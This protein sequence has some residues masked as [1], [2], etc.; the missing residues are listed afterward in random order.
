MN[1]YITALFL[2]VVIQTGLADRPPVFTHYMNNEELLEDTKPGVMVYTL[3]GYDPEKLRVTFGVF[4]EV[5]SVEPN[6]GEV[7]LKRRL[8]FERNQVLIVVF[9]ISDGRNVV[10]KTATIYLRD[11]NDVKPAFTKSTYFREIKESFPVGGTVIKDISVTDNEGVNSLLTVTC[12]PGVVYAEDCN[13]F[14]VE[15]TGRES[16]NSWKG[17]L[18]LNKPLNYETKKNY[19]V[20]LVAFDGVN[21][22]TKSVEIRIIDVADIPPYFVRAVSVA[23]AEETPVGTIIT[24][25]SAIDGDK[26]SPRDL[27]YSIYNS[28]NSLFRINED[29]G[30]ISIANRLNREDWILGYSDIYLKVQEVISKS[31]LVLG[32]SNTTTATTTIRVNILDINDNKPFFTASYVATIPEDIVNNE[33]IPNLLM[34]VMDNDTGTNANYI[35]QMSTYFDTFYIQPQYGEGISTT[36]IRVKNTSLIDYEKGPREYKFEVIAREANTTEKYSGSTTVTI[37]V[38]DVNDNVPI[39]SQPFYEVSVNELAKAG[40]PVATITATDMDSGK[41]GT[42]GIRYVRLKGMFSN[43]FDLNQITGQV[44]VASCTTPGKYPCLDYD[45]RKQINLTVE[46]VDNENIGIDVQR[47]LTNVIINVNDAN[48]NIPVF[49]NANYYGKIGEGNT[50]PAPEV[51]VKAEDVDVV[52]SPVRY[53][54]INSEVP[55]LFQIGLFSGKI[56]AVR[57]VKITDSGSDVYITMEVIASDGVASAKASVRIE[58]LDKNDNKPV[59]QQNNYKTC[60]P[61]NFAGGL[62]VISVVATDA[63]KAG[64]SNS[65]LSYSLATGAEGQFT[66]DQMGMIKSS[67]QARFDYETKKIYAFQVVARDN[68]SPQLSAAANVEICI[69]DINDIL[70]EFIPFT[71]QVNVKEDV[72]VGYSLIKLNAVDL[73]TNSQLEYRF[74]DPSSAINPNGVPVDKSQFDYTSFF[75]L[76][77][78]TGEITTAKTL[79]REKASLIT[80]SLN[81]VDINGIKP[82]TGTGTIIINIQDVNKIPPVF[83]SPWTVAKPFYNVVLNEEQSV[84]SFVTILNAIDADGTIEGYSLIETNGYFSVRNGVVTVRK[85]IDYEKVENLQFKAL[86]WDNV[87]PKMTATATVYVQIKNINDN[88]PQF[89]KSYNPSIKENS[90]VGTKVVVVSAIDKD[91]GDYG[92]IRYEISDPNSAFQINFLTGEITVKNSTALDREQVKQ[93]IIPVTA[94]DSPNDLSVRLKTTT[95]VYI[96]LSDMNDNPPVFEKKIYYESVVESI[97]VGSR[98]IDISARDNDI[99]R[100]AIV[101]YYKGSGD[102]EDLFSVSK[103]GAISVKKTLMNKIGNH[104]F[105]VNAN[106][107]LYTDTAQVTIEVLKGASIPPKWVIPATDN[108]VVPVLE[109]QYLGMYVYQVKAQDPDQGP[110]G[111]MTYSFLVDKTITQKTADFMINPV[112]GVIRAET[113]FDREQKDLYNLMLVVRDHGKNPQ[114]NNRRLRIKILDVNDNKPQF[115]MSDGKVMPYSFQVPE[116]VKAGYHIGDVKAFDKDLK[117]SIFYYILS[118]NDDGVFKLDV[119]TGSLYLM[120]KI[121]REIVSSYTLVIEAVNNITEFNFI[122]QLSKSDTD[123]SITTVNILVTDRNDEKPE[124]TQ[125]EY[126][127]CISTDDTL[128]KS[129]LKVQAVDK[130]SAG[131]SAIEYTIKNLQKNGADLSGQTTFQI[132]ER[133]GI[134]RNTEI[135]SK[136]ESSVFTMDVVANDTALFGKTDNADIQVFVTKKSQAVKVILTQPSGDVYFFIDQIKK[137]ISENTGNSYVCV[138]DIKNHMFANGQISQYWSDL[139]VYIIGRNTKQPLPATESVELLSNAKNKEESAFG[140]LYVNKIEMAEKSE[141]EKER[142]PL[143]IIMILVILFIILALLLTCIACWCIARSKRRKIEKATYAKNMMINENEKMAVYSNSAFIQDDAIFHA[144]NVF[145]NNMTETIEQVEMI[146]SPLYSTV[147]KSHSEMFGV[148]DP[149]LPLEPEPVIEL[150]LEIPNDPAIYAVPNRESLIIP[151]SEM[152]DEPMPVIVS[153]LMDPEPVIETEPVDIPDA[154]GMDVAGSFDELSRSPSQQSSSMMHSAHSSS[155]AASR[156]LSRASSGVIHSIH[157]SSGPHSI[158]A[159]LRSDINEMEPVPVIVTS[160]EKSESPTEALKQMDA[161][162]ASESPVT[163]PGI[164]S[165]AESDIYNFNNM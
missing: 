43:L 81:V 69:T 15:R 24:Q 140:G 110:S 23:V 103:N 142:I 150:P 32:D 133:D 132:G 90:S 39:P 164:M 113:V 106:D 115:P 2:G 4:G 138:A 102:P 76:D 104:T 22:Q 146:D 135:M 20:P 75:K 30:S 58:V 54:I 162:F 64:T 125:K 157:S 151:P 88:S 26:F 159:S 8:D 145:Y 86:A 31:P 19:Q 92:K 16:S 108:L 107:I 117:P 96:D 79:E 158:R 56:T 121:D 85:R 95:P 154:N 141:V 137:L 136:H 44:T 152:D 1:I 3:K 50:D 25:V 80:Q 97:P 42:N 122:R 139:F 70:P 93:I 74:V 144:D 149:D 73:D 118:G 57:P 63:D 33:A 134:L 77:V 112:T 128:M 99:D 129:I 163:T 34:T 165:Q 7:T 45:Y 116:D 13:T 147:E 28:T 160:P 55:G 14:R 98:I 71:M 119:S 153:T 40:D 130:D 155:G 6:S 49:P 156:N 37:Y 111:L 36:A 120:K 123:I 38:T 127:G 51:I 148:P 91:K 5:F 84:G 52:G 114:E 72:P 161:V 62:T 11:V 109:S 46:I 65:K 126:F 68:G 18:I 94:Y 12:N 48:D 105:K 83:S 29:T 143:L 60:I 61:E 41:L 21:K 17:H 101:T 89:L 124:F 131:S 87:E 66:I 47:S 53:S 59:F 27:K 10:Q 100:N 82:Q 9:T 67:F 35:F 78:N